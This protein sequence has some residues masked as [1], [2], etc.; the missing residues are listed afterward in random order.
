LGEQSLE[1][2]TQIQMKVHLRTTKFH[3]T[4]P[5]PPIS[6]HRTNGSPNPPCAAQRRH[7]RPGAS[8]FVGVNSRSYSATPC[9][10]PAK[11]PPKLVYAF[12]SRIYPSPS[13][14]PLVPFP[15]SPNDRSPASGRRVKRD[16]P[17]PPPDLTPVI[18]RPSNTLHATKRR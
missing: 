14:Q 10:T 4:D 2:G 1:S 7:D 17:G 12:T 11:R 3:V 18:T 16:R 9:T 5:H 13:T 6:S 15:S 8:S